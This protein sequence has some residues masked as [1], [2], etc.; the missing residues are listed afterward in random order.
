M[1]MFTKDNK[2][3]FAF[4]KSEL[5]KSSIRVRREKDTRNNIATVFDKDGF[6]LAIGTSG[7]IDAANYDDEIG[8]KVACDNATAAAE[9]KLWELYGFLLHKKLAG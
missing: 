9:Q 2:V 8:K 1:D 5:E 3:N 4:I 6:L 7:C